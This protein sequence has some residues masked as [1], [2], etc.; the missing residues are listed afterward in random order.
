MVNGAGVEGVSETAPINISGGSCKVSLEVQGAD[1]LETADDVRFY[2]IV[3]GGAKVLIGK[4]I[5]DVAGTKTMQGTNI[6]GGNLKLRI[7][8]M[9]SADDEYYYF[10]NLKVEYEAQQPTTNPAQFFRVKQ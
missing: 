9:V 6:T 10:D 4:Q 2:Q 3:D 8:T 5:D 7:E 1:G